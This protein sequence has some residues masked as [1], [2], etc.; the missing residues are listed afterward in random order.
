MHQTPL[1]ARHRELG[2]R[3]VEFGGW[4]MPVQYSGPSGGIVNE[5][6]ATRTAAGL[7]DLCHMGRFFLEGPRAITTLDRLLTFDVAGMKPGQARY[8]FLLNEDGHTL[9]DVI[10]YRLG[11][12]R[13][14]LVVNASNRTKDLAWIAD[15][16]QQGTSLE[17]ATF[18]LGM[19]AIQGPKSVS[20]LTQTMHLPLGELGYYT[21]TMAAEQALIVGRTGYT[22][23]DGFEVYLPAEGAVKLWDKL[24]EGWGP[25]TGGAGGLVP[26]GLGAR[27]TL[28]LEAAMP[29]YGHE[30][31]ETTT[32][33]E[34][35]LNFAVSWDKSD[36]IGKQALLNQKTVGPARRL[37]GFEVSDGKKVAR[38][39]Y[40]IF[41]GDDWVGQVTSGTYSPTFQK[42]LGMAYVR[43]EYKD[44]GT[45]L[46]VD[47]RGKRVP[48]RVVKRPF[49]KR[50]DS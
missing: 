48:I 21:C 10:L 44:L 6:L 14:F 22:G 2:A 16:L 29:L 49:Y 46:E 28:R 25:S 38:Q 45:E 5:H 19:I 4:D 12:D 32:P 50:K 7:F 36:F 13:W 15:H 3:M 24:L 1:N 35:G 30:L 27:D 23:E 39:G 47:V 8:G 31:D 17:D 33:V 9:D 41:K 18:R 20:I 34:A 43:S 26:V 37:V 11:L 42:N 40:P